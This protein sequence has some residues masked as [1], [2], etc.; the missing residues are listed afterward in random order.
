MAKVSREVA[1]QREADAW[2]LRCDGDSQEAIATE[3]GV[4]QQAV[5]LML[6]RVTRR[7]V[8]RLDAEAEARIAL[9]AARLERIYKAAIK[10]W[11]E[12][13]QPKQKSRSHKTV[14]PAAAADLAAMLDGQAL[15]G[16]LP[17]PSVIREVSVKEASKSDGNP[18]FLE[19]ALRADAELRKLHGVNAPKKIDLLDKRRPLEKLSDEELATRA[20]EADALLAAEIQ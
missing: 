6:K 4:T 9:H 13:K 1:R 20:R 3:L 17:S 11:D 2:R 18:I 8:G 15:I 12:S 5:S 7:V 10:A 19:V 16:G 14:V